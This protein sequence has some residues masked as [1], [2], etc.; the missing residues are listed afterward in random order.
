M[1]PKRKIKSLAWLDQA[2]ASMGTDIN[3]TYSCFEQIGVSYVY[4]EAEFPFYKKW[5]R[6]LATVRS[7]RDAGRIDQ[8]EVLPLFPI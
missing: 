4:W 6:F 2:A 7:F 8:D 5:K 3:G 1:K